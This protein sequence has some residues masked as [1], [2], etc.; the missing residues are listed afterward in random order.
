MKKTINF[1]KNSA[2]VYFESGPDRY[3]E[4]QAEQTEM[5]LETA[6]RKFKGLL[7]EAGYT[8]LQKYKELYRGG[9][10]KA[11]A[12]EF[13]KFGKDTIKNIKMNPVEL[14]LLRGSGRYEKPISF[15]NPFVVEEGT[16]ANFLVKINDQRQIEPVIEMTMHTYD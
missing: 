3:G 4:I 16:N 12:D 15:V 1:F 11:K 9:K 2:F 8:I 6:D 7:G 13:I 10:T 5:P 14:A